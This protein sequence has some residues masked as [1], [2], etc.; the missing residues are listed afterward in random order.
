MK[1]KVENVKSGGNDEE[2]IKYFAFIG[3]H[4]DVDNCFFHGGV[5]QL[6]A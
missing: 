6:C 4:F 1:M 5:W 3:H 2:K